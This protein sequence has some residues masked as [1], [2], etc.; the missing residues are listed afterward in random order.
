MPA[1]DASLRCAGCGSTHAIE[2]TLP[3]HRLRLCRSC[4][5]SIEDALGE[6]RRQYTSTYT[7]AVAA[8][9]TGTRTLPD[10]RRL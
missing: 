4:T 1:N 9:T 5:R 2:Y 7:F 3:L 6:E 8:G 10:G